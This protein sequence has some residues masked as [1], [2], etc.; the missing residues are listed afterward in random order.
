MLSNIIGATLLRCSYCA[1]DPFT[2]IPVKPATTVTKH[3]SVHMQG[4]YVSATVPHVCSRK[5]FPTPA[6]TPTGWHTIYLHHIA[7][8]AQC[9]RT[10]TPRYIVA[11]VNSISLGPRWIVSFIK[12]VAKNNTTSVCT[13]C[14]KQLSP[15]V[16]S[17]QIIQWRQRVPT[18]LTWCQ[19]LFQSLSITTTRHSN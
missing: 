17:P 13:L 19:M 12:T 8:F 16:T 14:S 11:N 10:H 9:K 7:V 6:L 4:N 1:N 15:P 3:T 18:S 5:L 2:T